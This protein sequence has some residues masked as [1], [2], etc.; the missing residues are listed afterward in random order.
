L[1]LTLNGKVNRNALP[2]PEEISRQGEQTV[3]APTN[4]TEAKL[5]DIWREIL[6][7]KNVGIHD[8]FFH[9]GG[10]SLLATQIIS[11][12]ARSFQVEL[13]VRVI[14]ETPTIAGVARAIQEYRKTPSVAIST[15]SEQRSRAQ[16]LLDRLDNLS[17]SE[18]EELLVELEEEEVAR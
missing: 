7:R 15:R 16:M 4:E 8:N 9:L 1:P 10:H 18:V 13:P 12:I 14:F 2:S 3:I 11:R 5:V 6:Q 17:D